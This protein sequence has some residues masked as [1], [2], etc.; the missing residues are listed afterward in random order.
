MTSRLYKESRPCLVLVGWNVNKKKLPKLV[1]YNFDKRKIKE[2]FKPGRVLHHDPQQGGQ[3]AVQL[4]P[5]VGHLVI[6]IMISINMTT[7]M[8]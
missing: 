3:L 4:V 6:I 5:V 7:M 8:K 1:G 2:K